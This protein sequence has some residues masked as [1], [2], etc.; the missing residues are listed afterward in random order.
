MNSC[1]QIEDQIS[2][3]NGRVVSATNRMTSEITYAP[4]KRPTSALTPSLPAHALR[5][6]FLWQNPLL[7]LLVQ[8]IHESWLLT[9]KTAGQ[10]RNAKTSISLDQ[11]YRMGTRILG[12]PLFATLNNLSSFSRMT[13]FSPR[14]RKNW[15][16]TR[17]SHLMIDVGPC[18]QTAAESLRAPNECPQRQQGNEARRNI[19]R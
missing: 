13:S 3:I 17:I 4:T 16:G 15:L 6:I 19:I 10:W 1:L 11:H 8:N 7:E 2:L 12:I 18:F 9:C 5:R 14:K